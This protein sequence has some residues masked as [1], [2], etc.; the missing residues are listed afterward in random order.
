MY[1]TWLAKATPQTVSFVDGHPVLHGLL[2][3]RQKL[4]AQSSQPIEGVAPFGR[5]L[6]QIGGDIRC[7]ALHSGMI[8]PLQ[9]LASQFGLSL[10]AEIVFNVLADEM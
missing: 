7:I 10:E 1:C 9:E 2:N 3:S 6:F 5:H 4:Q 8:S